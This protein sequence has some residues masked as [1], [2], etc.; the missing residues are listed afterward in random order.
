MAKAREILKNFVAGAAAIPAFALRPFKRELPPTSIMGRTGDAR[1]VPQISVFGPKKSGIRVQM[2]SRLDEISFRDYDRVRFYPV[3]R[4]GV[5]SIVAP[6]AR[7]NV[8]FTCDRP[9]IAELAQLELAPLIPALIRQM[10][11]GA[12]EFGYH[13]AEIRW[14]PK[15]DVIASSG[16]QA[17]GTE[18]TERYYPFVWTIN[19][20]AHFSPHDC[21]ILIDSVTGDFAGIRQFIVARHRDIPGHKCL[22]Y[23]HDK[24][25]DGHYGVPLTKAAVP[26]V[27][28]AVSLFDSMAKYADLF[29][30][31]GMVGR[32]PMGRTSFADGVVMDNADLM[33]SL[34]ESIGSGHRMSLPSNQYDTGGNKWDLTFFAPVSTSEPYTAM[35]GMVNDQIRLAIGV[36]EMASSETTNVGG[37]GDQGAE[38]KI[39]LFLQ[40]I[41]T[42]L[43]ELKPQIDKLLDQFRIYNFG[44]DAP[45]LKSYF[46]PVDMNVTKALLAAVV[47]ILSSGQP[48]QDAEGNLIYPDWAKILQ[49]KGIPVV[50]VSGKRLAQQL[51]DAANQRIGEQRNPEGGEGG[52]AGEQLLQS[53]TPDPDKPET[54]LTAQKTAIRLLLGALDKFDTAPAIRVKLREQLVKLDE[55]FESKHKRDENGKFT[56]GPGASKAMSKDDF[57]ARAKKVQESGFTRGRLPNVVEMDG[58][59]WVPSINKETK[60]VELRPAQ[61]HEI[62]PSIARK[63][64]DRGHEAYAAMKARSEGKQSAQERFDELSRKHEELRKKYPEIAKIGGQLLSTDEINELANIGL[65]LDRQKRIEHGDPALRSEMKRD[66]LRRG[67]EIPT[68]IRDGSFEQLAAFHAQHQPQAQAERTAEAYTGTSAEGFPFTEKRMSPNDIGVFPGMQYKRSEVSDTENQVSDALKGVEKYDQATAGPLTVWQRNDGST[69]VMNGHHRRELAKRTGETSVP[70]RVFSEADGVDFETARALGALQN[71]RDGKGTALDAAYV[72]KDLGFSLDELKR[73]GVNLRSGV[74]RDAVSLMSLDSEALQMVKDGV[75]PQAVAAG[76]ADQ[77]LDPAKQRLAIQK[78]GIGELETRREGEIIGRKMREAKAFVKDDGSG[79]LFGD[80]VMDVPWAESAQIENAV[81]NRLSKD[82]RLYKALTRGRAVGESTIDEAAQTTAATTEALARRAIAT[83]KAI[84]DAIDQ[85]ALEYAQNPN[86]STLNK[87]I[88]HVLEIARAEGQRRLQNGGVA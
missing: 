13:A 4:D 59:L 29:A 52:P 58:D 28:V 74:G 22:I 10:I 60:Q 21:R 24:E 79:N 54:Q 47:Q 71:V 88:D 66:L 7:A 83:T 76:I 19:R 44:H 33:Q 35:L 86:R 36:N 6:A 84:Q 70:V 16:L 3:I 15:F 5:R 43:D 75:V 9:E 46:E 40:N 67:I 69:Y 85:Q 38:D 48:I 8:H 42:Y 12:L 14:F 68:S 37:L 77:G 20:F 64:E 65:E 81:I 72:I 80:V 55:E 1:Y 61:P 31:P 39:G 34:V 56:S 2:A 45:P 30:V 73:A 25:Y 53:L 78:A 17:G 18:R 51:L 27:D 62:M 63:M 32:Y 57:K 26:F 49:D 11:R 82:E 41:E 23:T 50:S 87:A